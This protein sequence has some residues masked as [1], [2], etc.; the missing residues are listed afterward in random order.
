MTV[1]GLDKIDETKSKPQ[2]PEIANILKLV[3]SIFQV[4]KDR[5]ENGQT[6]EL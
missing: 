4:M 3:A 5:R 6:C 1:H 2:D